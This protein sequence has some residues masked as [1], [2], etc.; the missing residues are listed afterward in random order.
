MNGVDKP[1]RR[2]SLLF[3][4]ERSRL[5]LCIRGASL[6]IFLAPVL[7]V[8]AHEGLKSPSGPGEINLSFSS[9]C[10]SVYLAVH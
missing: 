3:E 7:T 10:S 6:C 2:K 4:L 5:S 1:K 8:C 9:V